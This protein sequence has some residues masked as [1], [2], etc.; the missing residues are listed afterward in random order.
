MARERRSIPIETDEPAGDGGPSEA[1][2]FIA[3]AVSELALMARLHRLETLAFL[4]DMAQMEADELIRANLLRK[5][6]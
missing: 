6:Q 4:L 2:R 1:A 5:G 3:G